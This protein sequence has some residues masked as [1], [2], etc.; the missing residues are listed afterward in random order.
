MEYLVCIYTYVPSMH[1]P[2]GNELIKSAFYPYYLKSQVEAYDHDYHIYL[3]LCL[4][5]LISVYILYLIYDI[6]L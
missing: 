3:K 2:N 5:L 1:A 6:L 4:K